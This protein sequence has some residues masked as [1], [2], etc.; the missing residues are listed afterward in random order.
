[1][2]ET[3]IPNEQLPF[4]PSAIPTSPHLTSSSLLDMKPSATAREHNHNVGPLSGIGQLAERGINTENSDLPKSD[5]HNSHDRKGPGAMLRRHS[6]NVG[7]SIKKTFK[8]LARRSMSVSSPSGT[9]SRKNDPSEQSTPIFPDSPSFNLV[10]LPPS[11]TTGRYTEASVASHT[12]SEFLSLSPLISVVEYPP[13]DRRLSPITPFSDSITTE[14]L[15]DVVVPQ[16]LQQGTL[17]V[18]LSNKKQRRS[19][20][21]FRLD[22]DQGQIVWE[23]KVHKFSE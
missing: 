13:E 7:K 12:D 8:A 22:A 19:A 1:M 21:V 3:P 9:K 23:S 10:D 18:K 5:I 20:F 11:E 2:S 6:V 4:A 15:V 17:L 16:L 14:S